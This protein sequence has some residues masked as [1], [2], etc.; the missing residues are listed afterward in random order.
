MVRK[1]RSQSSLSK[2]VDGGEEE[3]EWAGEQ[4][5]EEQPEEEQPDDG[6]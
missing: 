5:E 2:A 1:K 6:V 3:E 4:P